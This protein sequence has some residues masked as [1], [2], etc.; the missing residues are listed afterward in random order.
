MSKASVRSQMIEA[1]RV[2]GYVFFGII[3]CALLLII[4]QLVNLQFLQGEVYQER[5]RINME[6]Y[7]PIAASRGEIFDRNFSLA[8]RDNV[9]LVSNRPSFN[10]S[11]VPAKFSDYEGMRKALIN[12]SDIIDVNVDGIMKEFDRNNPWQRVTIQ[13]DVP[14]EKIVKIASRKE[15]YRNVDWE[16]APVRV[17][18][19]GPMFAHLVGYIGSISRDEYQ[20]LR[21]SGYRYYQKIGKSGIEKQYDQLLR[22]ID[23]NVKRIVDVKNRTEG[24][25][26]GLQPVSGNNMVLTVDYDV[27]KAAYEALEGKAGSCVV[28]KA[29]TGEIIA[30]VSKPDYDPNLIISKNNYE[31]LKRLNS[32][33]RRPFI[34]RSIQ[35]K[36]PPA[37]TFKLVTAISALEEEKWKPDWIVNCPGYYVLKGYKD[38]VI[39]DYASFGNLD[40]YHAIGKSASVYFY[41]M[42]HKIGP[43]VIMNYAN[44]FGLNDKSGVDLPGEVSGFV[45]SQKWKRKRFGQSWYDGDTINLSIGQGFLTVTPIGVANFVCGIVNSGVIYKPHVVKEVRT[46]DNRDIITQVEPE[47][48]KEIP[49]SPSTLKVVKTGMRLSVKEGTSHRLSRLPVE[50]AG[51]TGTAQT[52][53]DREDKYSQHAWFVGFGPYN[54][55]PEDSYV[56]VAM[57]EYGIAGAATAVPVAEKVIK[58]MVDK[59]YFDAVQE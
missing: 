1:F 29:S 53:S 14:F 15:V 3:S 7:I 6:D 2:R 49:L 35:S 16:V 5:A 43:T 38:T 32:D 10:I 33:P 27:Q 20:E 47:K 36:Y 21:T 51:K 17:Y 8:E 52:R 48:L 13:E 31:T 22:G 37:S 41:T 58:R 42:G 39:Y 9:V 56:V 45:P 46:Q 28:I 59:G 23:G 57:I 40:L 19:Y 44:H 55:A 18:N 50:W 30:M 25:E 26:V 4:F 12:L 24:E 54:G 34:N 11:T